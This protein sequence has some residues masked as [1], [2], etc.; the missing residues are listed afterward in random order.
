MY[1]KFVSLRRIRNLWVTVEI[2]L[3][4]DQ[5]GNL[6]VTVEIELYTVELIGLR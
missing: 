3:L 4:L 1:Q 5:I 6:R 2:V